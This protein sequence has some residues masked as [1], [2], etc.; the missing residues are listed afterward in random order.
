MGFLLILVT[1]GVTLPFELQKLLSMEPI[2]AIA[3]VGELMSHM[4]HGG[5]RGVELGMMAAHIC[6]ERFMLVVHTGTSNWSPMCSVFATHYII[7]WL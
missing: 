1:S 4:M 7:V 2:L 5:D 6:T 3:G